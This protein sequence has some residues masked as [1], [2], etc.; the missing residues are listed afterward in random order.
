VTWRIRN[1]RRLAENVESAM[2]RILLGGLS[3]ILE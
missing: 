3:L 1:G 2:L